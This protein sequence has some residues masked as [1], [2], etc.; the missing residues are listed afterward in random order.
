MIDPK[1][2]ARTTAIAA[3]VIGL[4]VATAVIGYF[5]FG[6]VLAAIRPIGV[7]G[8]LAVVAA[9]LVLFVPL[10]LA[11]WLV[12]LDEAE[13]G[14]L[15]IWGRLTREAASD[16]LPFSQLGG[17]V[18]S[19]RAVVLGGVTT[20]VAFGSC[21][22]DITVEV[23]AQLV[24]TLVGVWLLVHRLGVASG[25]DRLLLSLL[26]GLAIAAALVG[27]FIVMQRRGLDVIERLVHRMVPT[28][29]HH[30]TAVTKVV[31]AAYGRPLR[32]WACLGL[33]LVGWFGGAIGAWLILYF[34]G[35][36]LPFL[37]VVAIESLLFAIRNA[38]FVV[39]SGIGVQ[40]GAY[41]LLGPIFGLPP[42]AA[43]AL[44]LLKRARDVVVGV[45]VL[46]SWQVAESRRPL[47][48]V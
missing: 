3:A 7:S 15:F 28:A 34:I 39:P 46:L 14:P 19:A 6:A 22:V 11:W 16:V 12:A 8:F 2:R 17:L 32:L 41:A 31:E 38:A 37:S 29:A 26:G 4:F 27:G 42:E 24:Y 18:I 25:H 44:S 48:G 45:P 30:A 23:V 1:V 21:V 9:Q 33:H 13:R 36:P 35:H 40:E 20:P 10:G 47:R 5:N 43:L